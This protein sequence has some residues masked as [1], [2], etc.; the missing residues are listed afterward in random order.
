MR[1]GNK[2]ALGSIYQVGEVL[3]VTSEFVILRL[4]ASTRN[5]SPAERLVRAEGAK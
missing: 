2:L 1:Q 4:C 3:R 5:S